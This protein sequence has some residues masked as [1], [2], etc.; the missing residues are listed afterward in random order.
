MKLF[1]DNNETRVDASDEEVAWLT[2]YLQFE[3]SSNSFY[4]ANGQVGYAGSK[5]RRLYHY[6]RKTI[7]TGMA[8]KVLR[9]AKEQG[10]EVQVFDK[11][12]RPAGLDPDVDLDWL[13]TR[14]LNLDDTEEGFRQGV[15]FQFESVQRCMV[16]TR[17]IL[18]LPTGSGKTE[19]ACGVIKA[20]PVRWI[21]FAPEADLMENFADRYEM[22]T[23]EKCGRIGDGKWDVEDCR[24][25]SATFQTLSRRLKDPATHA[26][27][28]A[29]LQ[30]FQG[31][32]VDEVHQ[33]PA[34][35]FYGVAMSCPN[36]Y[37]RFGM[38]GTALLRGDKRN[39]YII[40]AVGEVIYRVPATELIAAKHISRPDV[41]FIPVEV[42]P[43]PAP[44]MQWNTA[45]KR[46]I[47]GSKRRNETLAFIAEIAAKPALLFV[48][49]E[50]HGKELL[51]LLRERGGM[52]VEFVHGKWSMKRRKALIEKLRWGDVDVAICTKVWQTGTDI[53]E[54]AALIIGT[55]GA[56]NIEAVQRVGRGTRVVYD[57]E[58]D[59]VKDEV[60]IWEI[61]D[62][63]PKQ[64]N[65]ATGRMKKTRA[66]MFENHSKERLDAYK[67]EG[68]PVDLLTPLEAQRLGVLGV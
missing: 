23:G 58:G 38:S 14:R 6:K 39:M 64:K 40:S 61:Y 32:F 31:Y 49:H 34:D 21:F 67:V 13:K 9:K 41:K 43:V 12:V 46:C 48:R 4:M 57:G 53:P 60:E 26:D 62:I 59:L 51:K 17:G 56:S 33:L 2:G 27:V 10:F 11:R 19:V 7:P 63:D 5:Q 28:Y 45:Y 42:D 16:R 55:G 18:W 68:Y 22:R 30:S 47:K 52:N 54:L 44:R 24:V 50:D 36:A 37:Y 1:V 8:A 29:F 65:P 15:A 3:D 35:D 25:V 66:S 20:T